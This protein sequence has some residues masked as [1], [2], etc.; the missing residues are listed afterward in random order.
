MT[1]KSFCLEDLQL[2]TNKRQTL[3]DKYP[4]TP[5]A[6]NSFQNSQG[7]GF[8]Q[9]S[10]Q[11]GDFKIRNSDR[12]H[13]NKSISDEN[14][15]HAASEPHSPNMEGSKSKRKAILRDLDTNSPVF[16]SNKPSQFKR[17]H[18]AEANIKN[19]QKEIQTISIKLEHC[20]TNRSLHYLESKDNIDSSRCPTSMEILLPGRKDHHQKESGDPE[21]QIKHDPENT[22]EEVIQENEEE[23][24]VQQDS[25][26][27]AQ[28]PTE[29][30]HQAIEMN[31]SPSI[32]STDNIGPAATSNAVVFGSNV[33]TLFKQILKLYAVWFV[34]YAVLLG[35]SFGIFPYYVAFI[36]TWILEGYFFYYNWKELRRQQYDQSEQRRRLSYNFYILTLALV[37]V[38]AVIKF[39]GANFPMT[40]GVVPTVIATLFTCYFN[41]CRSTRKSN[42]VIIFIQTM[43]TLQLI[44]IGLKVDGLLF[45]SWP[46]VFWV[47][48]ASLIVT[49]FYGF[50]LLLVFSFYIFFGDSNHTE[51][52]QLIGLC[53]ILMGCTGYVATAFFLL[54]GFTD[55]LEYGDDQDF[56][57]FALLGGLIHVALLSALTFCARNKMKMYLLNSVVSPSEIEET[58]TTSSQIRFEKATEG[59][60]AY[61][62]RWTSSYFLTFD[63]SLKMKDKKKL[64]SMKKKVTLAKTGQYM[65]SGPEPSLIPESLKIINTARTTMSNQVRQNLFAKNNKLEAQTFTSEAKEA[66]NKAEEHLNTLEIENDKICY[67]AN[68]LDCVKKIEGFGCLSEFTTPRYT[69]RGGVPAEKDDKSCIICFDKL[70]DAVIMGCGHGGICYE[71]ALENCKKSQ[72]CFLCRGKIEKVLHIDAN[73]IG[74]FNMTKVL[75]ATKLVKQETTNE[76]RVETGENFRSNLY[77][78]M[79]YL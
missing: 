53:S 6:Y 23:Q 66:E 39:Q 67:S 71:C 20:N 8:L 55:K 49:A 48:W 33:E 42:T 44:S 19:Q 35:L 31:N 68:D 38:F 12:A 24:Q 3:S 69:S 75:S 77:I 58:A 63:Q 14:S 25:V 34:A 27:D 10:S 29:D 17:N 78:T 18:E 56:I 26:N 70:A 54:S 15:Y 30:N 40:L 62:V 65:K 73:M 9:L 41:N 50:G 5:Q 21:L 4:M 28:I 11:Y 72:E 61:I 2:G 46:G 13:Q 74:K 16:K 60:P 76:V 52:Y 47:S 32:I 22:I 43:I 79:N 51:G 1:N 36:Y 57:H 37:Q 7:I 45:W 59:L 64:L